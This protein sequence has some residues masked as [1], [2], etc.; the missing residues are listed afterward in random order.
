MLE[1]QHKAENNTNSN[2][3][4]DPIKVAVAAIC[5]V[6]Q[7]HGDYLDLSKMK[8]PYSYWI[9]LYNTYSIS[10]GTIGNSFLLHTEIKFKTKSPYRSYKYNWKTNIRI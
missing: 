8:L 1:I 4:D 6:E 7:V 3:A 2:N 10:S 9:I 5:P